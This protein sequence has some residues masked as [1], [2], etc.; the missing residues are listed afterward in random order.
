MAVSPGGMPYPVPKKSALEDPPEVR[1]ALYE[2]M[3][4]EGSG[5]HLLYNVYTDLLTN[6]AANDT[7]AEFIRGKIKQIVKDPDTARK[8]LP[9]YLL[10]TKRQVIDCGYFESFNQDNVSLVDLREDPI[11]KIS[12][13]GIVTKNGNHPLDVLVLATGFDAITGKLLKLNPIGRNG[14]DLSSA[15]K[16]KFYTYLGIAIPEFPNLFMIHGAAITMCIIQ[17]AFGWGT[18]QRLDP[19]LHSIY[20]C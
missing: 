19:R 6:K 10:G 9:D 8:L 14:L 12:A 17:Y 3:W 20:A 7:L 2:K 11:E 16:E 5:L 1:T 15:W 18:S 13:D 4:N